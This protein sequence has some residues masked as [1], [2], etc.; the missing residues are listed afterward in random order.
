MAE[1]SAQK[2]FSQEM[3]EI[4]R[5]IHNKSDTMVNAKLGVTMSDDSVWAEGLLVFYEIFKFLEESL[6]RHKDSLMGDLLIPG[7]CRTAAFESDLDHYLGESWREGYVVRPEV[8]AYLDHLKNIEEKNPYLLVAYV[9]HLYM[10]LFS[11]GQILRAKRFMS[12]SSVDKRESSGNDVTSYGEISIGSLKKQLK[13]AINS[14][15]EN[16]DVET[17]QA[18]LEEGVNV[19]KLNNTIIASV[20]GVDTVL[21]RRLLK[22]LI[23]V[24]LIILFV[25]ALVYHSASS[26]EI[27]GDV[28]SM[29]AEKNTEL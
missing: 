16:L 6:E 10:G 29:E 26:I 21:R 11:G 15:A 1:E 9:Y 2:L 4:T 20:K 17:R 19:F 13:A 5:S 28:F 3:R 27:E 18:V 8:E 25:V 22:L 24:I 12:L 14:F 23:A 7:M